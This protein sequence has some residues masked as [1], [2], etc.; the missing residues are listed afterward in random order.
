MCSDIAVEI[1]KSLAAILRTDVS[2]LSFAEKTLSIAAFAISDIEE[3]LHSG[4][5]QKVTDAMVEMLSSLQS[6]L[7][8]FN[9]TEDSSKPRK[10]LRALAD[11]FCAALTRTSAPDASAVGAASD[12][13]SLNCQKVSQRRQV[14]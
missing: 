8:Q 7:A 1:I 3:G 4:Q 13:I 5:S 10:M 12:Q 11:N 9:T 6:K 2:T 14:L